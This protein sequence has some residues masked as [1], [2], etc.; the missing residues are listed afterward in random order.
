MALLK[1]ELTEDILKLISCIHFE[2][3]PREDEF[4]TKYRLNVGID[5]ASLYG[6]SFI[7]EDI[8]FILGRYDEHLPGTENDSLGPRFSPEFEEY[9]WTIHSYVVE[10]IQDIEELVHQFCNKGGLTPGT[11]VAKS[12]VR[13]WEKK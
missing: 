11:Y 10:H 9:M 12:N 13:F 1:V 3:F 5:F 2:N 8:S 7:F 4:E 6:G